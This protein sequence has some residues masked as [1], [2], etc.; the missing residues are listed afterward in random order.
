MGELTRPYYPIPPASKIDPVLAFTLQ[1]VSADLERAMSAYRAKLA[2][3]EQRQRQQP[4]RRGARKLAHSRS[5][6]TR[7]Q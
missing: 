6:L 5:P 7:R 1:T 3:L 4:S 2:D